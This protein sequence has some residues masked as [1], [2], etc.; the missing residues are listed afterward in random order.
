MSIV[1]LA[2]L[3]LVISR[4]TS[5]N[6]TIQSD[7]SDIIQARYVAEAAMVHARWLLRNDCSYRAPLTNIP[8]MDH[9]YDA[10]IKDNADGSIHITGVGTLDGG[11]V[12][13]LTMDFLCSEIIPLAVYWTDWSRPA[14]RRVELDGSGITDTLSLSGWQVPKP[15]AL[16]SETEKQYWGDGNKI[17]VSNLNGSGA[18]QLIDCGTCGITGLAIDPGGGKLYWTD[19]NR[20]MITRANLDGTGIDDLIFTG[21]GSSLTD[22]DLDPS[23]NRMYWTN[24]SSGTIMK[25]RL[26]GTDIDTVRSGSYTPQALALDEI[27]HK[28][29]WY[30]V[31]SKTLY[32]MDYSGGGLESRV[33]LT[34]GSIVQG[35]D[36]DLDSGKIYWSDAGKGKIE[37]AN[38]VDGSSREEVVDSGSGSYPWGLSLGPARS[39]VVPRSKGPFWTEVDKDEINRSELDG[40]NLQTIIGLVLEDPRALKV[41]PNGERL[42]WVDRKDKL[43][44][45]SL[46][47][48]TDIRN[49]LDCDTS[50]CVDIDGLALDPVTGTLFFAD[51]DSDSI[52]KAN[53]D[54]SGSLTPLIS[55][56][57]DPRDIALDLGGNR[58]YWVDDQEKT[59]ESA[60]LDGTGRV[61]ILSDANND[62]VSKPYCIAIDSRGSGILFWYDHA[63]KTIY[64]SNLDGTS[65]QAIVGPAGISKIRALSLDLDENKLYWAD[66]DGH[67]MK[68]ANIDGSFIEDL[69]TTAG[70]PWGISIVPGS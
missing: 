49:V 64:R 6:V 50:A 40:T 56:L 28:I 53:M 20:N 45:S 11:V 34:T 37:R 14:I 36:L 63:E 4:S 58:M 19:T 60:N 35:I 41:D 29:Y 33:S 13:T 62:P 30:D 39:I 23:D 54:G 5:V 12:Q 55:G 57:G 1:M 68:R 46:I 24:A 16:N 52:F 44:K 42:Y 70:K 32:T 18:F 47:D 22:I 59:L 2:L 66:Y 38:M 10:T 21:I 26:D 8:F 15:F 7:R 17:F 65:I 27:A 31:N 9:S 3:S 61:L 51:S 48:G 67:S 43:V 25:A 69:T